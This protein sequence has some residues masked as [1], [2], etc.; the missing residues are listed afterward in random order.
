M[1]MNKLKLFL[2]W[3]TILNAGLLIISVIAF[4]LG[5]ELWG[6]IHVLLF[7]LTPESLSAIIYALLGMYKIFWLVFNLV[8]YAAL[9]FVSKKQKNKTSA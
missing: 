2:M 5:A 6:K 8:P 9:S 1:D 4:I 3:S 7:Q